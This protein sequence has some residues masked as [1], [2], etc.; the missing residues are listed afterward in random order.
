MAQRA[1][2]TAGAQKG[3]RTQLCRSS[4]VVVGKSVPPYVLSALPGWIQT[5]PLAELIAVIFFLQCAEDKQGLEA[6]TD[7]RWVVDR[8]AKFREHTC[9]AFKTHADL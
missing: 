8:A 1:A 3:Q 4:G 2:T 6:H 5:I 7:C 9:A